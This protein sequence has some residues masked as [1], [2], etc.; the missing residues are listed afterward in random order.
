MLRGCRKKKDAITRGDWELLVPEAQQWATLD[1]AQ[2]E[3]IHVGLEENIAAYNS[4]TAN[5]KVQMFRRLSIPEN[6]ENIFLEKVNPIQLPL[7]NDGSE[8]M[9]DKNRGMISADDLL[10]LCG[11]AQPTMKILEIG[12]GTGGTT[13]EVLQALVSED[14]IRMYSQYVFTDVSSGFFSAAQERF[15]NHAGMAYKVLDITKDPCD[16]GFEAGSFDL[17]VAANV[18][19]TLLTM[20]MPLL[21]LCCTRF[22]TLLRRYKKH[23]AMFARSYAQADDCFFKN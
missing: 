6:V 2:L 4:E 10:S 9:Y 13:A 21:T 16:Q 5:K 22:Y 3:D 20:P 17:I 12:G 18:S 15:E 8:S 19:S 14:G 11:H 1:L 23:F 7:E